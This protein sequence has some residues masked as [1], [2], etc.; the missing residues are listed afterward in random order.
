LRSESELSHA[1]DLPPV[2][3]EIPLQGVP[4]AAELMAAQE[5]RREKRARRKN[6]RLVEPDGEGSPEGAAEATASPTKVAP[7]V[8]VAPTQRMIN[9]EMKR[10]SRETRQHP[11]STARAERQAR[12]VERDAATSDDGEAV[13]GVELLAPQI[14]PEAEGDAVAIGTEVGQAGKPNRRRANT[15]DKARRKNTSAPSEESLLLV[16]QLSLTSQQLNAAHRVIGRLSAERDILRQHFADAVGIP[17]HEVVIATDTDAAQAAQLKKVHVEATPPSRMEKPNYFG[18]NDYAQMRRRRQ[19]FVLVLLCVVMVLWGL[20]RAGY[21]S[22]PDN[23]SRDSLGSVPLIGDL[24]TYFLAGWL[25]FRVA[26]VSSKGVRWVF[27][28]DHR[29]RRRR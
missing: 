1:A 9:A 3:E 13:E 26:K 14:I 28:S 22:M 25:F 10:M 6:L 16:R 17:V 19:T 2:T 5:A 7:P 23:I 4:S 20:S 11:E 27:P 12:S 24:M 18:G 15:A 21:W 29:Q 8:D